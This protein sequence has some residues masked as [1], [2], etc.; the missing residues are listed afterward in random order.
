MDSLPCQGDNAETLEVHPS[1][2]AHL[3]DEFAQM[4]DDPEVPSAP[5]VS[6]TN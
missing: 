3:A 2:I 4:D 1:E 5:C 6:C